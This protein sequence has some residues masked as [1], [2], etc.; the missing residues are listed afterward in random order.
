[1]DA[2]RRARTLASEHKVPVV[3]EIILERVT[4]IA[5]GTEIDNVGEFEELAVTSADAPT[6]LLMM[7]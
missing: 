3:V 4:N 7:D 6:A 5:M 1:G 2:L